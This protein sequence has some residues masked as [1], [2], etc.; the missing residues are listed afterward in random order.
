[1]C[2]WPGSPLQPS[3]IGQPPRPPLETSS[4]APTESKSPINRP[5]S[6]VTV[7]PG[8]TGTIRSGPRDPFALRF[9]VLK[10]NQAL[11]IR[12]IF[13]IFS[14]NKLGHGFK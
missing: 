13:F 3:V 7:V 4:L 14:V 11:M 2:L 9:L 1:M 5:S 12:V 10:K 6:V 8:G